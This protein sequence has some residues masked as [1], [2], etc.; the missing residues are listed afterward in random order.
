[1]QLFVNNERQLVQEVSSS[2]HDQFFFIELIFPSLQTLKFFNSTHHFFELVRIDFLLN[3]DLQP[4]LTEANMSPG[5]VPTSD[6]GENNTQTYEQVVFNTVRLIGA[7][8][9]LDLKAE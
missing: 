6:A 5:L 1:M 3:E 2:T 4:F 8:N 9:I 7:H